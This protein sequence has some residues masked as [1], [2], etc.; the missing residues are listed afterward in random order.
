MKSCIPLIRPSKLSDLTEVHK[1]FVGTIS[2]ICKAD[3]SPEQI[4]AWTSSIEN[5]QRWKDKIAKQYFLIAELDS[6][7]VGYASLEYNDYLDLL[8]VHKDFQRHAIANSLFSA[9]EVEAIRYGSPVLF[10]DVSKT[11]KP[12]FEKRGF[13]TL[14]LQTNL[15]KGI[16]LVNYRM[17]KRFD[18]ASESDTGLKS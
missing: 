14:K 6:K 9:I 3:Y 13:I 10:S 2:A 15:I 17:R 8:Y 18:F 5:V 12:F 7:I 4:N 1:L 11:A 16:E